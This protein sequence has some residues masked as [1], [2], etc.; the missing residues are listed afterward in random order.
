MAAVA[1]FPSDI[2]P[3]Q[4]QLEAH[5][6][7]ANNLDSLSFLQPLINSTLFSKVKSLSDNLTSLL[8]YAVSQN[9]DSIEG[10]AQ[11]TSIVQILLSDRNIL[12]Q[13]DVNAENQ[14]KETALH[15]AVKTCNTAAVDLLVKDPRVS[16]CPQDI[17]GNTPLHLVNGHSCDRKIYNLIVDA[18]F[19]GMVVSFCLGKTN[20]F[21]ET[22]PQSI[23]RNQLNNPFPSAN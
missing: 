6:S 12:D 2:N 4:K 21:G 10:L 8:H 17:S 16:L 22:A 15:L 19:Q 14:F 3:I 18:M 20:N 11:K 23:E 1:T 7:L 5:Q 13:F 9:N